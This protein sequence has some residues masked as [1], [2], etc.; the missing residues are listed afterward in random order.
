MFG[1]L[2]NDDDDGGGGDDD[3]VQEEAWSGGGFTATE[4]RRQASGLVGL[5]NQGAT[6]YMNSLFQAHFMTPE[7]RGAIFDIDPEVLGVKQL[8]AMRSE[9]GG[10]SKGIE[11]APAST[12][13]SSKP[14][15]VPLGLQRLFSEMKLA[16]VRAVS[17]QEFT[18]QALGW[19]SDQGS[20][21]HDVQELN[22]LL[23][24]WVERS[25]KGKPG[26]DI[27]QRLFRGSIMQYIDVVGEGTVS[28]RPEDI[29]DLRVPVKVRW[30][31]GSD[32]SNH[33][34]SDSD[35]AGHADARARCVRW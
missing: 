17:T 2:F 14:R 27:V 1:N 10:E 20:V 32:R 31:R 18:E 19:K 15:R 34:H 22:R 29:M 6:C 28:E 7:F 33:A 5:K 21:Q 24:D 13:K 9:R 16:E 8:E 26:A 25:L 4:P 11:E 30:I 23:L 12:S 35:S 3:D